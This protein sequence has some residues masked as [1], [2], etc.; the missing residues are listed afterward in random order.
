MKTLTFSMEQMYSKLLEDFDEQEDVKK[1]LKNENAALKAVLNQ[2]AKKERILA[3]NALKS[4]R[5]ELM[6]LAKFA[7]Q[8]ELCVGEVEVFDVLDKNIAQLETAEVWKK[9]QSTN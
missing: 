7:W 5:A 3:I 2:I 9:S 8:H 6:E 1:R 4:V